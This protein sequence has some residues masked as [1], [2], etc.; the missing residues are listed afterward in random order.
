MTKLRLSERDTRYFSDETEL[1]ILIPHLLEYF[2]YSSHAQAHKNE[3][4]TTVKLLEEVN[5]KK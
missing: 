2:R 5:P 3:I 1:A 4:S